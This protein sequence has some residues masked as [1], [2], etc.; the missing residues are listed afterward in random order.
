MTAETHDPTDRKKL[1]YLATTKAGRRVYLNRTLVEADFVVVL[2]GRGYD[3]LTG[4]AGAE[5]AIFP[6]LAD[7]ETLAE[8]VGQFTT[9]AAR[10]EA[11]R[12][13][14]RRPRSPGCS[15]RRSSCR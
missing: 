1:A 13:R 2:T 9:D 15:A 6:A 12:L 10:A 7:E 14:A 3:P 8:S 11:G 5:A 4:Y